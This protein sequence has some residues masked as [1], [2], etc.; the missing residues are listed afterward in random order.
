VFNSFFRIVLLEGMTHPLSTAAKAHYPGIFE[1]NDPT[2]R[3]IVVINFN[4]DIGDYHNCSLPEN[5]IHMRRAL[6]VCLS[7]DRR[8]NR[9]EAAFDERTGLP[10]SVNLITSC[11][12]VRDSP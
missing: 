1:H 8:G 4:N 12:T 3:L 11:A 5:G 7:A 10:L 6:M 2:Q 9:F